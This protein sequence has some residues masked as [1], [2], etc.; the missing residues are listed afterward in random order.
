MKTAQ[1]LAETPIKTSIFG[2]TILSDYELQR[3]KPMPSKL[4]SVIQTNIATFLKYG[5]KPQYQVLTEL[6]IRLQGNKY[7][8]DIALYDKNASNWQEEEI[9]M[10]LPPLLAIEIESPSQAT[11]EMKAKADKYLSAGVRSVWLVMPALAGVMVLHSAAKARFFS[12]G[13]VVDEVLSI[14][15]PVGEIFE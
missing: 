14:R 6:S 4:H 10:T 2:E 7:V 9:E 12:D 1:I 5:Y 15:I 11:D 3:G 13:D 8:P